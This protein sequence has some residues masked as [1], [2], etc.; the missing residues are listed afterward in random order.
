MGEN[1]F[2][3]APAPACTRAKRAPIRYGSPAAAAGR[4]PEAAG[5]PFGPVLARGSPRRSRFG[6][7]IILFA[8]SIVLLVLMA[9]LSI[10]VGYWYYQKA[11]FQ[12]V[13]DL[14]A[15]AALGTMSDYQALADQQAQVG[16]TFDRVAQ[17]NG[18]VTSEGKFSYAITYGTTS[19]N[20]Y[21]TR[22]TYVT[23]V[24]VV[25]DQK[26]ETFF[27][28]VIN[29]QE[30]T[31][32]TRAKVERVL[33]TPVAVCCGVAATRNVLFAGDIK[34]DSHDSRFGTGLY[35]PTN[36]A[37][38]GGGT[39]HLG[40]QVFCANQDLQRMAGA[41]KNMARTISFRNQRYNGNN[42]FY[43]MRDARARGTIT[44]AGSCA[45]NILGGTFPGDSSIQ[46]FTLLP[47]SPPPTIGAINDNG[48]ISG[49]GNVSFPAGAPA[50]GNLSPT[51]T[52]GASGTVFI[53]AGGQ[54]HFTIVN[55]PAT[56]RLLVTGNAPPLAPTLIWIQNT[57]AT[58][59]GAI[60]LENAISRPSVGTAS[61]SSKDLK[62]LGYGMTAPV[63]TITI[64]TQ[65]QNYSGA[66]W[67]DY[68]FHDVYAPRFDLEL[69]SA[70]ARTQ[71]AS[72]RWVG[73]DVRFT[74]G[75]ANDAWVFDERLGCAAEVQMRAPTG[76]RNTVHLLE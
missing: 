13:M 74:A 65:S 16:A 44:C 46:A 25:A 60:F 32:R 29:I 72:G 7:T 37:P 36:A 24:T 62:I 34:S 17:G 68:N 20:L 28:K 55:V 26:V 75:S 48:T 57:N 61:Q 19:V 70:A 63:K 3:N 38:G 1:G 23:T 45:D 71:I 15:L 54:Y 64:R 73:R 10:D 58:I 53:P 56:I 11:K 12:G 76:L 33:E 66:L 21:G 9:G 30:I 14:A 59:L 40:R 22:Q 39:Y 69:G 50:N 2:V 41:A 31:V 42:A 8:F 52:S 6:T 43:I 18:Y 51:L 27:W 35:N 5:G 49:S 4:R 67:D 47:P